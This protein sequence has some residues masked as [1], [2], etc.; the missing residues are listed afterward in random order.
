MLFDKAIILSGSPY[1]VR[2]EHPPHI[3]LSLVK[4]KIPLLGICYGA[5]YL[6][7]FFGGKVSPSKSREY[8]RANLKSIDSKSMFFNDIP[9]NSQ[10][11]MS[12]GD[13]V[14]Q[15][16]EDFT[17]I[18]MLKLQLLRLKGKILM[19]FNFIQKYIILKMVESEN[20]LIKISKITQDWTPDSFVDSTIKKLKKR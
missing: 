12:H 11:W 8:G 2:N 14:T 17:C 4:G 20:F 6:A 3:D 7:H 19:E 9:D 13:K 16:P 10:V 5:Q 15:M 1:S 18:Q